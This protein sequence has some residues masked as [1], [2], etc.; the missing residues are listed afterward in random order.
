EVFDLVPGGDDQIF[1]YSTYVDAWG[2]ATPGVTV[3]KLRQSPPLFGVARVAEVVDEIPLLRDAT[4]A[5]VREIRFHGIACAEFKR[6]PRDGT[7]RFLEMNGRATLYNSVLRKAGLDV[8]RLAWSEHVAGCV[9]APA[10]SGWR[11]VWINL[12]AD[13]LYT[14]FARRDERPGIADFVAPYARPMVEA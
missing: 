3:R 10:L 5:V 2:S 12:H 8:A 14:T 13:L 4:L 11:G 1:A 7:F 6:D 9:E